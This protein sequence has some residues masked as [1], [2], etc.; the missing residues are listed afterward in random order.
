MENINYQFCVNLYLWISGSGIKSKRPFLFGS[1]QM[2]I[3]LVPGNSA[4]TVTAYY[5]SAI[6]LPT[7]NTRP[8]Y[9]IS[10]VH[11]FEIKKFDYYFK[12]TFEYL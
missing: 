12:I 1:I 2:L 11:R 3:K 6:I 9:N 5:V 7:Y 10:I 4:G 8:L